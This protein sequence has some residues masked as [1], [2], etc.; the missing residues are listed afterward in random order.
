MDKL[1]LDKARHAIESSVLESP[2]STEKIQNKY[3]KVSTANKREE[4]KT[5]FLNT[6]QIK[7]NTRQ[8]A[9]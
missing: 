5:L 9:Q 7:K 6:G 3:K 4:R 2:L 1:S 8:I